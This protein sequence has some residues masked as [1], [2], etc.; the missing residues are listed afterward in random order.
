[1]IFG[2]L[3]FTKTNMEMKT[4]YQTGMIQNRRAQWH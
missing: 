2:K 1:M 4:Y 3:N